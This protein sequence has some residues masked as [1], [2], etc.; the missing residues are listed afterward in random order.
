MNLE[1]KFQRKGVRV[2]MASTINIYKAK[3]GFRW[4]WKAGNGEKISDSGESYKTH[5][6]AMNAAGR[7]KKAAPGSR[8]VDKTKAK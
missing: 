8:L 7:I 6:G 4:N 3:D 2:K 5:A 1:V